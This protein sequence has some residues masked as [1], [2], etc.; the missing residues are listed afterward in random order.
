MT[1]CLCGCGQEA[2]I[3]KKYVHGH[4]GSRKGSKLTEERKKEIGDFFRGKKR[5]T[6]AIA[7]QSRTMKQ[8]YK[9]GERVSYA[10][11]RPSWNSGV[12]GAQVA[13]NKGLTEDDSRVKKYV[14]KGRL[15]PNWKGG[16]RISKLGYILV[17]CPE[18]PNHNASGYVFEHRLVME[19]HLGR[20]LTPEEVVH[21]INGI[22]WDNR[23]ENLMLF[24][25]KGA[26]KRHHVMLRRIKNDK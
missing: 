3:G 10:K 18:H 13:W 11:G 15:H 2:N 22:V 17:H 21:H 26:H 14:R 6:E 9:S 1:L 12:K 16:R 20:Y 4:N 5:S 8:Q 7:K 19:A 25:N 23:I 24:E